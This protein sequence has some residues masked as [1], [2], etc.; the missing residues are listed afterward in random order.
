MQGGN[1]SLGVKDHIPWA[2][3]PRRSQLIVPFPPLFVQRR[4][5]GDLPGVTLGGDQVPTMIIG[6]RRGSRL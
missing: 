2:S 6:R 4:T 1:Q 3:R 5:T